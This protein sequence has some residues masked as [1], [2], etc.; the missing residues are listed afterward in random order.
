MFLAIAASN[1]RDTLLLSRFS[2]RPLQLKFNRES[3]PRIGNQPI[4][5][6]CKHSCCDSRGDR[7][8]ENNRKLKL[9]ETVAQ[10]LAGFESLVRKVKS[11]MSEIEKIKKNIHI[12]VLR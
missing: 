2:R 10:F 6:T 1:C 3:Q 4:G 5:I 8:A 12:Y 7:P 11:L 9:N